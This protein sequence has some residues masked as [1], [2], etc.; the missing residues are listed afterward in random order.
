MSKATK[1]TVIIPTRERADT[2]FH[3]LR[4]VVAQ[5]YDNLSIIV[6]DNCSLDN[7]R[8]V[9]D[10]FRDGRIKYIN[11]GKRV[12]MTHNWEYALSHVTDGWLTFLGDDDGILPRGLENV[13]RV[14]DAT[15]THAVTSAWQ[16]YFW[17]R[18]SNAENQLTVPLTSGYEIRSGKEWLA[19]LL[20]GEATYSDLPW[21]YTGGFVDSESIRAAKD[22]T[23]KFF[24]SNQ[25]DVY[26]AVALSSVLPKYVRLFEPV[27]VMGVSSHSN[28]ASTFAPGAT[29][30]AAEMFFSE[31][32]IPFHPKLGSGRTKSTQLLHYESYLQAEHLHKDVFH[33]DLRDQLTLA[34]SKARP[35]Y[36][37]DVI[38]YCLSVAADNHMRL[39]VVKFRKDSLLKRASSVFCNEISVDASQYGVANIYDATL[40]SERLYQAHHNSRYGCL[41]RYV[42][43]IRKL[44]GLVLKKLGMFPL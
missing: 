4:T 11:T 2:L 21:V 9:A 12:S 44:L 33:V 6:N 34:I 41:Y 35:D 16:F 30:A 38:D 32:N 10:S 39:E 3:C 15:G 27:C 36:R 25:P 22:R 8:E 37:S 7:T 18:S 1:F 29:S 17:P 13:A 20:K 28:G 43:G 14:I 23:G 24:C 19:K 31:P 42:K 40:L 5:D 26:S